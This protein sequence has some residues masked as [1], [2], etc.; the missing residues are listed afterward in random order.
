MQTTRPV[1]PLE[2]IIPWKITLFSGSRYSNVINQ[3]GTNFKIDELLFFNEALTDGDI[4]KI[5]NTD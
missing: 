3:H 5:A 1:I 2:T 4:R